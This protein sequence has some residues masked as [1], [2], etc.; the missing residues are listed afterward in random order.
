M[1]Y[2]YSVD[3]NVQPGQFFYNNNIWKS[4]VEVTAGHK[5]SVYGY[6]PATGGTCTYSSVNHD[7]A[8]LTISDL[9][10][11]NAE[12]VC[13]LV[14]VQ[15]LKSS[16]AEKDIQLGKFDFEGQS[17]QNYINVLVDHIYASL[18]CRFKV[19]ATYNAIRS[20]QIRL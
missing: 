8:E 14:G 4:A 5:Y 20:I 1:L 2:F 12:D 3:D 16:T 7:G 18:Q 17:G 6:A 9:T 11:V 19:D 15:Q 13:I 10:T